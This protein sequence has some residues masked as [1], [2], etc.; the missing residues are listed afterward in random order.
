MA[1]LYLLLSLFQENRTPKMVKLK[2][3]NVLELELNFASER[4]IITILVIIAAVVL[5][6]L[7]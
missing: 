5:T 3:F 1:M 2:I 4:L 6:W 7:Q